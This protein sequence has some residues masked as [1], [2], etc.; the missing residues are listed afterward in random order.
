MG[1]AKKGIQLYVTMDAGPHVKLIFDK[2]YEQSV[3]Q[4]FPQADIT[5][6]VW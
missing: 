3:K 5:E 4:A 1:N 6:I 2:K